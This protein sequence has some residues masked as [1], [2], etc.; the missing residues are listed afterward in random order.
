M[1]LF[2]FLKSY[3]IETQNVLEKKE[4]IYLIVRNTL[5]NVTIFQF[6]PKHLGNARI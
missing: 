4:D 3:S 6:S 1:Y 2:I 5:S